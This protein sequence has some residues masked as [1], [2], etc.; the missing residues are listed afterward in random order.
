M[1][2]TWT[3]RIRWL[4]V[5]VRALFVTFLAVLLSFAVGLLFGILGILIYSQSRGIAPDLTLAYRRIAPPLALLVGAIVL[6][7]SLLM[8]IRHYRQAKV[9]SSIQNSE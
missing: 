1:T 2:S 4:L 3:R 7:F 6:V 9:L 8:E 5:P